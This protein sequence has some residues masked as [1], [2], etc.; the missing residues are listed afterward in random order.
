[1]RAGVTLRVR[2]AGGVEFDLDVP[3]DGTEARRN[4]DAHVASGFLTV[5]DAPATDTGAAGP[6]RDPDAVPDGSVADVTVWVRG[7]ADDEPPADGWQDRARLAYDAEQA[8]PKPR[9]GLV[10]LLEGLL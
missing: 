6:E 8:R 7:A 9:T 4:F 5:L 3:E 10:R 2:G 1:M